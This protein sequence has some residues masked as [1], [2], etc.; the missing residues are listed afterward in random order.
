MWLGRPIQ[1]I[2]QIRGAKSEKKKSG[3][4]LLKGLEYRGIFADVWARPA[5]P[6]IYPLS[7][8]EVRGGETVINLR[9]PEIWDD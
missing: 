7:Q 4:G 6:C 3:M 1:V 2:S 5:Q 8:M 9:F